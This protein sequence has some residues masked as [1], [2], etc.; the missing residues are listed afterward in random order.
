MTF[1]AS[2][3]GRAEKA[4]IV[5]SAELAD[6]I[7][8]EI[9]GENLNVNT[10]SSTTP[11]NFVYAYAHMLRIS[12]PQ[13]ASTTDYD[14][15][16]DSDATPS[17]FEYSVPAGR[18]FRLVRA[19]WFL[20]DGSIGPNAFGGI[21]GGLTNGC[22]FQIVDSNGTDVLLDF[23]DGVPVKTN[24]QFTKLAGTD[25]VA[26]FAAGDDWLPIRFTIVKAGKQM[27]LT[28]GQRVRWTNRDDL[29]PLT[30]FQMMLQ[31]YFT[32]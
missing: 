14:M 9:A 22:L 3:G 18:T 30:R 26:T 11:A 2:V 21:G 1:K 15:D 20:T 28:A 29:S 13:S 17:V 5:N 10:L 16:T 4:Y 7:A 23:N 27:E 19:N 32:S 12:G 31:G 6:L 24:D 25:T 8:S